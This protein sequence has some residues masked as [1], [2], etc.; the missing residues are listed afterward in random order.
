VKNK[1]TQDKREKSNFRNEI[2]LLR[3]ELKER[4]EAAM[5]ESLTSANVVLATN[6]APKG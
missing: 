6:T 3:K 4:E 1:K 2:K 5:L